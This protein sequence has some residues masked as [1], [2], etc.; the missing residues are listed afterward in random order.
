VWDDLWRIERRTTVI[1]DRQG[2]VRWTESG[3][4]CVD[5]TRTLDALTKLAPAKPAR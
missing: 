1:V 2:M 3:S 4:A 5:T